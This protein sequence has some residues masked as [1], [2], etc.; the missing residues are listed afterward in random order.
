MRPYRKYVVDRVV[1]ESESAKSFYLRPADGEPLHRF[2][3]GQ[4]L[5]LKLAVNGASI[6]RCYT[7]SDCF[8]ESHYRLTI[9]REPA[10]GVDVPRGRMSNH[11]HDELTVNSVVEAQAP[12]GEFFLDVDSEQ[13]VALIAGGIGVTPMISMLNACLATSTHREI[14]VLYAVRNSASHAFKE[15]LQQVVREHE[16][17]HV[18]VLY[19]QPGANDVSGRDFDQVGR[20]NFSVLR[21]LLPHLDMQFFICGPDSMMAQLSGELIA[22][23]VS[24]EQIHMEHFHAVKPPTAAAKAASGSAS[25]DVSDILVDFRQSGRVLP[26]DAE[27]KSLLTFALENDVSISAG[28]EYGDCGTCLTPLLSGAVAYGHRTGIDPDPGSCLPC[29]CKPITSIVLDA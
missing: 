21:H 11:F 27:A 26:W 2:L 15:Y 3:P 14:Y 9:K 24:A 29:S 6:Y 10:Q 5:P 18:S 17:V 19:S 25:A 16:N 23:G 13:A 22:A 7:L 20:L 1:Q 12:A 8:K 28:C 4:H